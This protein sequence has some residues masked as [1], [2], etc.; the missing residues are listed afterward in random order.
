M[1]KYLLITTLL[2]LCEIS[3][4]QVIIP[5]A[6]I[7]LAKISTSDIEGVGPKN[8]VGFTVGAGVNFPIKG[9]F[10]IQPEI[11]FIQKG[12]AVKEDF[13]FSLFGVTESFKIDAKTVINYL[14]IPVLMNATFGEK[15][16][17]HVSAGPSLGIGLGGKYR[18]EYSSS[19]T[20]GN[21]TSSEYEKSDGKVKFGDG[22]SETSG[23]L[24]VKNRLDFGIQL[25][26]GVLIAEKIMLD[27][28]YGL[29]LT[30]L[31]GSDEDEAKNRV[32]QFTVGIP[33]SLN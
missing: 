22:G 15:T 4:G 20:D 23:D 3:F 31:N 16:K 9:V 27:I 14:E 10:S 11:V 6:G 7:S 13:S 21:V 26:G 8:V 5:K 24:Y 12:F 1:K 25:G 17:V 18:Y 33:I 2:L 19:S 29:G 28:R 30:N 32:L